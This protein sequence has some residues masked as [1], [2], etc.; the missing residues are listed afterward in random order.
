[1]KKI[2]EIEIDKKGIFLERPNRFVAQVKIDDEEVTCHV[3]DSGRIKE[4]LYKGNE[5][6]IKKV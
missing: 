4:L 2:Y 5:V 1:M 3:H 6:G